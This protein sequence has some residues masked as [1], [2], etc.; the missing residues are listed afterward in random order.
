M[1]RETQTSDHVLVDVLDRVLD[2]GIVID[3]A[4]RVSIVGVE[5]LGVDARVVVASIETY[6]MHADTIAY[7]DMAAAPR[8]D[9]LPTQTPAP[10][11]TLFV[12]PIESVPAPSASTVGT[13]ADSGSA[14]HPDAAPAR[15]PSEPDVTAGP[16]TAG[17]S[18]L[19]VEPGGT[20]DADGPG[21][22]VEP[23]AT[24]DADGPGLTVEPGAASDP[25]GPALTVEPAGSAEQADDAEGLPPGAVRAEPG[26]E[27]APGQERVVPGE[28]D[29]P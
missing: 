9:P 13:E 14:A 29:A 10:T 2:K 17:G 25:D 24:A 11:P 15:P 21:L 26:G 27:S 3:A 20:A 19:T 5:L 8:R 16:G 12:E 7:T 4:V 22:T 6:L 18:G 1:Q 23:G 28:A